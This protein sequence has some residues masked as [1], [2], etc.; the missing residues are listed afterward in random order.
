MK[1]IEAR[2]NYRKIEAEYNAAFLAERWEEV[3][4]LE[5]PL[6]DTGVAMADAYLE[7]LRTIATP[8]Q[9][10]IIEGLRWREAFWKKISAPG[11]M[12][13]TA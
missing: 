2:N 4:R 6:L 8:E 1:Q 5:E 13:A 7:H 9:F 10:K 11:F 12:E 3:E